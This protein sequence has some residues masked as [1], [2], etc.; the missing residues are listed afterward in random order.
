VDDLADRGFGF[1][2]IE[3]TDELLIRRVQKL[4]TLPSSTPR[5]ANSLQWPRHRFC[6]R[7]PR[8]TV[9]VLPVG[10]LLTRRLRRKSRP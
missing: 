5:A 8:M 10:R 3:K 9:L 4:M 2:D 6:R 7:R 1:D